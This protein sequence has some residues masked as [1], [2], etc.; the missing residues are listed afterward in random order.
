MT[1]ARE[2]RTFHQ[3][4]RYFRPG[5]PS[6]IRNSTDDWA[7]RG[8]AG[9]RLAGTA[10]TGTTRH[11]HRQTDGVVGELSRHDIP[12]REYSVRS[13]GGLE[14]SSDLGDSAFRRATP[15]GRR[16]PSITSTD[17]ADFRKVSHMA[18]P[19]Q[20][21]VQ[22][23]DNGPT[24]QGESP[25][26]PARK[27]GAG[28]S[29]DSQSPAEPGDQVAGTTNHVDV[30]AARQASV[31]TIALPTPEALIAAQVRPVTERAVRRYFVPKHASIRSSTERVG[32]SSASIPK[33][34][35]V[36][37]AGAPD[38]AEGMPAASRSDLPPLFHAT[39]RTP[40]L[41]GFDGTSLEP[42]NLDL[43]GDG[44]PPP[45]IS[46][47]SV[48]QSSNLSGELW[49][50]TLSLREWLQTYLTREMGHA[51]QATNRF[52]TSLE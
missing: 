16:S 37:D 31:P 21:S 2:Q 48:E 38:T 19:V 41:S 9:G 32:L 24:S 47:I 7:N 26:G 30:D 11:L 34:P 44:P 51:L 23:K 49:L 5:R 1:I 29:K 43:D 45:S 15:G 10:P 35:P 25:G 17:D 36:P 8:Q 20:R 50:D 13:G 3:S 40:H 14:R 27:P 28:R 18:L 46:S 6:L 52:G 4:I 33:S 22:T 39:A 12:A 42:K